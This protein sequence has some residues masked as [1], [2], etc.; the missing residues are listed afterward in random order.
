[1]KHEE[2]LLSAMGN[3][4]DDFLMEADNYKKKNRRPRGRMIPI[5]AAMMVMFV[6]T[7][8]AV[9]ISLHRMAQTDMGIE[10]VEKIP[11][12]TEYSISETVETE[13]TVPEESAVVPEATQSVQSPQEETEYPWDYGGA[14]QLVSAFCSGNEIVTYASVPNVTADMQE[15][16]G[17]GAAWDFGG[18]HPDG[19]GWSIGVEQV[20]YEAETETALI[21]VHLTGG[22]MEG[23]DTVS[24]SLCYRHEEGNKYGIMYEQVEIPITESTSLYAQVGKTV[25]SSDVDLDVEIAS[26]E[27]CAGYV[28][29]NL[30][31]KPMEQF[32][33][34]L[35]EDAYAI[36]GNAIY[37]D[38]LEDEIMEGVAYIDLIDRVMNDW[39]E[40]PGNT[41]SPG[42]IVA[43]ATLHFADG[44]DLV[45]SQQE[46][47]FNAWT[48][49]G[50]LNVF[51]ETGEIE[52]RYTFNTP[53]VLTEVES[54]TVLGENYLLTGK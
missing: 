47:P 36:V 25:Q 11:E 5:A 7:A 16:L 33:S 18:I 34:D 50:D 17:N 9:G 21:K 4:E 42:S 40:G 29:V 45:I 3:L 43:D 1:M 41:P 24:V 14:V 54:I 32:Y 19:Y 30:K 6:I 2:L 53:L 28:S 10:E 27:V 31:T 20:E 23:L 12:Y 39:Q 26:V 44:S 46:S 35:G 52:Y 37:R 51:I 8:S 49:E 15:K 13:P 48:S 22:E 38:S